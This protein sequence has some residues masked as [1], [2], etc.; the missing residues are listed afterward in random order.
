MTVGHK[1]KSSFVNDG[2]SQSLN[3]EYILYIKVDY[4]GL[5]RLLER[6]L[7]KSVK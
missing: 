7:K 2:A 1:F 6:F 4:V 3:S 5:I